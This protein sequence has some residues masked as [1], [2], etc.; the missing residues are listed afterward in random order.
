MFRFISLQHLDGLESDSVGAL[1]RKNKGTDF[2]CEGQKK[3]SDFLLF[4]LLMVLYCKLFNMRL[5]SFGSFLLAFTFL[6]FFFAFALELR[7]VME[8]LK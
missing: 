7:A 8:K 1:W 6:S 4:F 3:K 2:H 5:I